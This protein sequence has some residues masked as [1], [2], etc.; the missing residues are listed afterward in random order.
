METSPESGAG[1]RLD[2]LGKLISWALPGKRFSCADLEV[3][4]GSFWN[5]S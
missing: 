2:H 5:G 4:I 1:G 3:I